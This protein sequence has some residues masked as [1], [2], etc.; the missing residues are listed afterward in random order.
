MLDISAIC[1]VVTALLAYINQRF[2]RLPTTIGVMAIALAISLAMIGLDAAGLDHGLRQGEESFLRA[3][4]FSDVLIDGM[5]S[6]LLFAAALHVDLQALRRHRWQVASLALIGTVLSTAIV[7]LSLW[8][9]LPLL[10]SGLGLMYCLLFGAL[11]S[12]TDPI[13]VAGILASAKAPKELELVIAGE[14][15]FNDGVGVVLFALLLGALSSGV[16]PSAGEAGALLLWKR[17]GVS[18]SG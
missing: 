17:A 9:L 4:D 11:I 7:G 6:L 16:A 13:A 18:L 10:G 3:I 1:L 8:W 5:L 14:S 2:V 15:L 12:P